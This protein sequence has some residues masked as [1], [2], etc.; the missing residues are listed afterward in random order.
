[1]GER[2]HLWSNGFEFDHFEARNCARCVKSGD[3][4][5]EPSCDLYDAITEAMCGD[6]SFSPE[7]VARFGWQEEY[8]AVLGWPCKEF[9]AEGPIEPKPAAR[10]MQEAGATMLPGF[11]VAPVPS[12]GR[13]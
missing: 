5:N 13:P 4:E 9:Q 7:I 1:M 6:G 8:R 3:L 10:E 12:G 2:I 11:D